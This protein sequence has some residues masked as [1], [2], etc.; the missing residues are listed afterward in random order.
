MLDILN[1]VVGIINLTLG[2]N[3][4]KNEEKVIGICGI[5]VGAL[6][7]F[8]GAVGLTSLIIG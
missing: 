8:V 6:G 4:I 1:T 3:E 5:I 2:I 7:L